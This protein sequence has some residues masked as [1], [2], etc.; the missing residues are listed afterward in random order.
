MNIWLE[1]FLTVFAAFGLWT[2]IGG[3]WGTFFGG[4]K[5]EIYV[6]FTAEKA[7][8]CENAREADVI[9]FSADEDKI[10]RA[11]SEEY[12]K[13]Y[14]RRGTNRWTEKESVSKVRSKK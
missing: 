9:V 10:L 13:I 11:L 5:T 14:I 1:V 7:E 4:A 8:N 6:Y 12:E 3:L 2:A